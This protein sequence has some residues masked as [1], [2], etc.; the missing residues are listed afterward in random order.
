MAF[1]LIRLQLIV[2]E[3]TLLEPVTFNRLLSLGSA[4][5]VVLFALPL[6][7]GLYTYLVPLQIGSR[8]LAFPRLASLAL[9]LYLA[10]GFVLFASFAYT[11]TNGTVVL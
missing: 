8:T 2:P 4:W 7:F 9:W 6:A 1:L 11:P 10:G 3:N 5:L